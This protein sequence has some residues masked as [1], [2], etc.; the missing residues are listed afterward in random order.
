[1][2]G[3]H[4]IYFRAYKQIT[5]F[6][7]GALNDVTGKFDVAFY[8]QGTLIVLMGLSSLTLRRLANIKVRQEKHGNCEVGMSEVLTSNT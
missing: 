1:M 3:P 4:L 8:V 6:L 2:F 5:F 7:T